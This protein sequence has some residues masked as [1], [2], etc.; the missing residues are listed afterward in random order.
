MSLFVYPLSGGFK[1]WS[2]IP[3]FLVNFLLR[4]E[5]KLTP[6]L[7]PLMAFRMIIVIENTKKIKNY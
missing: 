5:K 2:L 6:F 1:K 4:I 3:F 7:G